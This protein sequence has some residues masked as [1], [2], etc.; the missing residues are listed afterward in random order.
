MRLK[1][2]IGIEPYRVREGMFGSETNYG[3]NGVFLIPCQG[4]T[5]EC[6]VSDGGG[7]DHVSVSAVDGGAKRIPTWD[8]MCHVKRMFW[9]DEETVIQYHPPLSRSV[10]IS[11]T[12]LHL[13]RPQHKSIPLPP[14]EFV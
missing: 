8:E 2:I 12:T 5:L 3:N 14:V 10:N 13:W 4:A 6:I 9:G 7:W 1:P 11:P